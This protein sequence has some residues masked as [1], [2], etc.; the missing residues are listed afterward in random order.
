MIVASFKERLQNS[1]FGEMKDKANNL[2]IDISMSHLYI[3]VRKKDVFKDLK[4]Y[5]DSTFDVFHHRLLFLQLFSP[6]I[7]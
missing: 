3:S 7:F 1:T 5:F 2:I 6:E 4:K